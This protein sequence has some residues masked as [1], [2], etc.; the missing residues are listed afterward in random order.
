MSKPTPEEIEE[1]L[2][3][4]ASTAATPGIMA[5]RCW[6]AANKGVLNHRCSCETCRRIKR[7]CKVAQYLLNNKEPE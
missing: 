6:Y 3:R 7:R 4:A 5:V 2:K 1:L